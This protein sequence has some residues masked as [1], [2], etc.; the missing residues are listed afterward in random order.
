VDRHPDDDAT[1]V[2]RCLSGDAEAWRT[3][4][5]RHRRGLIALAARILP[6]QDAEDVTDA[7]LADLWER[8]KL[9]GYE[10]R[11]SLKTWLSAV[12][13]NTALNTRRAAVSRAAAAAAAPVRAD[14]PVDPTATQ[15]RAVLQDAIASLDSSTKLLVLLYY[16]QDLSLEDIGRLVGVSKSTLSRALKQARNRIRV[17]ADRLA[18]QRWGTSLASLREGVDL[19][20][21]DLD[22]RAACA[23]LG[24][25]PL[26]G[27]S[28]V[29]TEP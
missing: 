16:E 14:V 29:R 21:L 9:A 20:R 27:V 24:N 18:R 5:E 8:G 11:S 4:V 12:A 1:L 26:R 7:V 6:V 19:E 2:R 3:L 22:M 23:D 13:I 28:K 25:K 17:E 10:E 15:L